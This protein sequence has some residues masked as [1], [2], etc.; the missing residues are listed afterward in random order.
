MAGPSATS[1]S[2]APPGRREAISAMLEMLPPYAIRVAATLRVSD[3]LADG[4]QDLEAL[5]RGTGADAD[6]L[7]RLLRY[8]ACLGLYR[9]IEPGRF[10]A[11]AAGRML[12][13]VHPAGL[14]RWLDLDGAAGRM[15]LALAGL[16]HAV[17]TGRPGYDAVFGRG[18]WTDLAA[19]RPLRESFDALMAARSRRIAADLAALDWS[20]DRRLVDVGG[21]DGTILIE[22]LRAHPALR[23]VLVEQPPAVE[24]AATAVREADLHGRCDVVAGDFLAAVPVGGD[25]YLL[26]DVLHDWDDVAARDILCRCAQAAGPAGRVLVVE[27]LPAAP[28]DR[29]GLAMDLKMLLLFGG[30]QRSV[31]QFA[32]LAAQAGLS[33]RGTRRLAGGFSVVECAMA[34]G[35]APS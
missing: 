11:T 28:D 33:C 10:V 13:E 23:G 26:V 32:A 4:A 35:G 7:G 6:A 8:L 9:E 24:R 22:V 3:V 12:C 14:R 19:D 17:R 25:V 5:A 34:A 31:E 21:G 29:N 16:A 1:V 2:P 18:F 15:E 30:R 20:G 27:E